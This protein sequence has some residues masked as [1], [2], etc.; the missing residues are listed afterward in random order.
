MEFVVASEGSDLE[1]FRRLR[2]S[3]PVYILIFTDDIAHG[4]PADR[5]G[6]VRES[7]N[8]AG[9]D[10]RL[11]LKNTSLNLLVRGLDQ[12]CVLAE[13]ENDEDNAEQN[14]DSTDRVENLD[15]VR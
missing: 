6:I 7:F 12:P 3:F 10:T 8:Y 15:K 11:V 13:L 4:L 1:V 5:E 14:C 9:R 2:E